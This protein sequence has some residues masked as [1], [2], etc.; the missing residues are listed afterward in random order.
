MCVRFFY[1]GKFFNECIFLIACFLVKYKMFWKT[2]QQV[3][4][5][6]YPFCYNNTKIFLPLLFA[7]ENDLYRKQQQIKP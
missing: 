1:F 4:E 2:F 7:C 6:N 5:N 3:N